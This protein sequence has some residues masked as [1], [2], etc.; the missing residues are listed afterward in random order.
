MHIKDFDRLL[1]YID[2]LAPEQKVILAGVLSGD[3]DKRKDVNIIESDV[4]QQC[5]CPHCASGDV[6]K[7]GRALRMQRYRCR[8]CKRTFNA[9]TGT[10]L[11][12]LRKKD[13]WLKYAQGMDE[14]R[15]IRRCA[16][17]CGIAIPTAFRWRH[18]F[19]HDPTSDEP[20]HLLGIVEADETFVLESHK[21]SRR[22]PGGRKPRER[23]GKEAK[24]GL[25]KEQIPIIVARDHDGRVL[26]AVLPD[27]TV[28]SIV[29]ALGLSIDGDN[30]TCIDGGPSL[31]G[32]LKHLDVS[33][34]VIPAG[35]RAH[36]KNPLFHIQNAYLGRLKG[37]LQRFNGVATKY[38][39]NYLGWR[40]ILEY[41][42]ELTTPTRFVSNAMSRRLYQQFT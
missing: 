24:R 29:K 36:G 3:S 28:N 42:D 8:A 30:I 21:G 16:K 19:L 4:V 22:L 18:R 35:R 15:S 34:R 37:W 5:A 23:G 32:G 41:P 27:R 6:Q 14:G 17:D 12:R 33:C 40:R 9:L 26:D 10:P 7:W 2:A 11:A 1:A 25:A 20:G 39:Q 38:L 13:R 31:R